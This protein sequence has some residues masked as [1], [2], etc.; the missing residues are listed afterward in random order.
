M[1]PLRLV[2]DRGDQS[3]E[4][5]AGPAR[6]SCGRGLSSDI[7]IYDPT[8]SRRH[9]ELTAGPTACR[10]RISAAPTAPSSTAHRSPRAAAGRGHRHLRQSAPADVPGSHRRRHPAPHRR[11]G[12]R[13]RP[14]MIVRQLVGDAAGRRR[15]HQPRRPAG[16][17]SSGST[18]TR[19]EAR[20]ANKLSMLLDVSQKLA[21]EFDLDRLLRT[22]VDMTFEIMNVD[23]VTILLRDE[24]TG[25]LVPTISRSRSRATRS[26]SRCPGR[27]RRRWCR[28]GRRRLAQRA[29]RLALQGAVHSHPERAERHVLAA[30]GLRRPGAR[31]PL[32]RQPH[33]HQHVHRR[34]PAVPRRVQRHRGDRH[35]EQPLRRADPARGHGALQLRALLRAQRR[36]RDRAAGRR[37]PAGRRAPSDHGA[38]QRHPRLHR[39]G[40][41]RWARTPSPSS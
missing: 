33:H 19:A 10:S 17:A 34:G 12:R 18:P 30:H 7:A 3:F 2:S 25:E 32:R 6:W 22:V 20:Q 28:K 1:P 16:A 39:H 4:L 9:A 8:I 23:R 21:G 5:P 29:G 11:G 27:S 24:T 26:R 41:S 31:P 38:V 37:G 40:R 35:Q 14:G 15:H 13:R 36:G